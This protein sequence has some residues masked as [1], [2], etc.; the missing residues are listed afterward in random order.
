MKNVAKGVVQIDLHKNESVLL[1][2]DEQPPEPR[3]QAVDVL[4]H[5]NYWG[6]ITEVRKPD[7][8]KIGSTWN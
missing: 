2:S 1:Y 8:L 7:I 6:T 4:D 3:I 5:G